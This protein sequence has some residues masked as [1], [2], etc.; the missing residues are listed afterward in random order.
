[1]NAS[2]SP[3]NFYLSHHRVVDQHQIQAMSLSSFANPP[4]GEM[5]ASPSKRLVRSKSG[6][7][8]LAQ[9]ER[10]VPPWNLEE[11]HWVKDDEAEFCM[12]AKCKQKFDFLK[13]R[14]RL[15]QTS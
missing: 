8:I 11:P 7:K 6:L 12:N 10:G 4:S 9:H 14:V 13:R 5:L 15:L 2:L 3:L 1:M